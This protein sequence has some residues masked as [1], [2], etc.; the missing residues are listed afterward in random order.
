MRRAC[1][2]AVRG[3]LTLRAL[4]RLGALS[5]AEAAAVPLGDPGIFLGALAPAHR[6][7]P[8]GIAYVPHLIEWMNGRA[9]A[10]AEAYPRWRLIDVRRPP[11]EVLGAIASAEGVFSSSLHGLVAADALGVPNRWVRLSIP[12]HTPEDDAFKFLDYYSAFGLEREPVAWNALGEAS[13]SP[14]LPAPGLETARRNLCT[15]LAQA[16]PCN[17]FR[18]FGGAFRDT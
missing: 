17:G 7:R 5:E 2:L 8:S 16:F 10:V 18:G 15:A 3:R 11:C 12:G 6:A 13:L 1:V 9:K 4:V 14:P